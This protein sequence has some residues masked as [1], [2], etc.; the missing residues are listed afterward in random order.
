MN[1]N[2]TKK[3]NYEI[4]KNISA[5]SKFYL[6]KL[7]IYIVSMTVWKIIKCFTDFIAYIT[8]HFVHSDIYLPGTCSY[9][10]QVGY[11]V[12]LGCDRPMGLLLEMI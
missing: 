1:P 2:H 11:V 5:E 3:K 7:V 10:D 12:K 4:H 9:L 6:V 8:M